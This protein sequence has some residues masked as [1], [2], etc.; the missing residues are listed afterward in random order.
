M[1]TCKCMECGALLAIDD[2][3]REFAFCQYCG[4]KI[5]LDDYRILNRVVDEAKIKEE[6]TKQYISK[7]KYDMAERQ[8]QYYA[9]VKASKIL[10][11]LILLI[12]GVLMMVIGGIKGEATGDGNSVY[13]MIA[14]I[15]M[16]P[17]MGAF[18]FLGSIDDEEKNIELDDRIKVPNAIGNYRKKNYIAVRTILN[19]AGFY[20]V[21]CIPMNDLSIGFI[22]K[23]DMVE[24]VTIEGVDIGNVEKSVPN[25]PIVITYHSIREKS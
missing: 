16:F 7:R 9:R 23:P 8:Q 24:T 1:R 19:D 2:V 20:N 12:I 13:Y 25:A 4:T 15:G 11:G 3:N 21:R 17:I 14:T 6:E 22:K 10:A 18:Y 5:M